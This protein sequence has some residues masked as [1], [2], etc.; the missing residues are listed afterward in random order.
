MAAIVLHSPVESEEIPA[1]VPLHEG[2]DRLVVTQR[3]DQGCSVEL[4][5]DDAGRS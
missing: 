5:P 1:A 4:P 2:D 3:A